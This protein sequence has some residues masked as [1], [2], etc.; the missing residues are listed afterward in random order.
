[1]FSVN[2]YVQ[3]VEWILRQ[4]SRGNAEW[5]QDVDGHRKEMIFSEMITA[6]DH[7]AP[8]HYNSI[9]LLCM[10]F[11]IYADSPSER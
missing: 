9:Q 7:I 1:M 8:Y 4:P 11:N 10:C 2:A 5:L 6:R 3:Y